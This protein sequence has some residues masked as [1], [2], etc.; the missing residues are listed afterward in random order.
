MSNLHPDIVVTSLSVIDLEDLWGRGKRGIILD[1]DNT[2]T[3]WRQDSLTDD[4][5]GLIDKAHAMSYKIY[6]LSNASKDRAKRAAEKLN[7]GFTAPGFKPLRWGY[8]KALRYMGLSPDQVI[9]IG[10]QMFTDIWGGNRSGCYTVLVS[11]LDSTEFIGTKIMR[12]LEL[13]V[14]RQKIKL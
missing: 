1:L 6:L 10:D 2:I 7:V 12:V 14:G 8:R 3:P 13:I 9:V 11:P 5:R 4:A